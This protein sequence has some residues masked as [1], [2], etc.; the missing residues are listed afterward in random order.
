MAAGKNALK[1]TQDKSP[2]GVLA[3]GEALNE[4]CDN[5]HAKY[6]RGG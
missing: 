4:S 1:A 2:N 5:C 3:A 6:K